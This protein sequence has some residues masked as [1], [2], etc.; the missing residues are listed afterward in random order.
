MQV[1]KKLY[2]YR[3]FILIIDTVL[4]QLEKYVYT[5]GSGLPWHV[6]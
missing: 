3:C 1:Y 6:L 5:S 4:L 2:I